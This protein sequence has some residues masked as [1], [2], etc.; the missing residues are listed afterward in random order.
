MRPG[1]MGNLVLWASAIVLLQGSQVLGQTT[2]AA[3]TGTISDS[4]G[5]VVPG[6]SV[7]AT[8]VATNITTATQS[9]DAGVYTI[10]QLR[11]GEYTVRASLP[12]FKEFL[13]GKLVLEA[14]DFRRLDIRM[15][16]RDGW[17]S[18][19]DGPGQPA[20]LAPR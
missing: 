13:A 17:P 1:R 9:N 8:H 14:R 15:E 19:L 18:A 4:T 7:T 2:F 3:L 11:E 12:G 10:P 16:L 5:A 6:V 20:P